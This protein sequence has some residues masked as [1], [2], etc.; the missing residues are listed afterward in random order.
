M[1][2]TAMH[3][4]VVVLAGGLLF[5]AGLAKEPAKASKAVIESEIAAGLKAFQAGK[6]QDSI[7][8]LQKAIS[9]MQDVLGGDLARYLPKAPKGWEAGEIKKQSYAGT[10]TATAT[11]TQITRVYV[12]TADKVKVRISLTN[13]PQLIQG[14]KAALKAFRNPQMLRIINQDPKKQAKLIDRDGWA[15]WSMIEKGRRAA[16]T[17]FSEACALTIRLSQAEA[18]VL[19]MFL[20]S[21][22][23]KGLAKTM[24]GAGSKKNE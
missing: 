15:G 8:H 7:A 20:T 24:A 6:T 2:K 17:A 22:D 13:S 1:S 11:I 3:A 5:A 18:D 21:T 10:G 12:R 23:L 4:G 9:L 14:Q 19:E 16:V